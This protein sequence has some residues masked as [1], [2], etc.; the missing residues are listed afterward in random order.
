MGR[1][2]IY[3]PDDL[4]ERI[5]EADLNVSAVCQDALEKELDRMEIVAKV[6]RPMERLEIELWRGKDPSLAYKAR[7]TGAWLV[8]PDPEESRSTQPGADKGFYYGVALTGKGQY[9]VYS[10]HAEGE[11]APRYEAYDSLED[12][13][14]EKWPQNIIEAAAAEV[15]EDL[16][17]LDV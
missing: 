4:D 3:L 9:L 12:A 8:P 11:R 15:G 13:W 14:D 17:E 6:E 5:T 1:R 2:N 10:A 7:F 16:Y